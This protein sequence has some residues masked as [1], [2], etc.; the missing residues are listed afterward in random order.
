MAGWLAN[1]LTPLTRRLFGA[2]I[3][4]RTEDNAP[5]ADLRFGHVARHGVWREIIAVPSVDAAA[6]S[7]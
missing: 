1:R 7:S 4:R 5:A 6:A 3:N 2:D